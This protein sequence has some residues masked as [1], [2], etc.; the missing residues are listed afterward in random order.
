MAKPREIVTLQVGHFSNFIGAHWWNLQEGSFVYDEKTLTD[1][2]HDMLFREGR[3][4]NGEDTYVPR[5]VAIDLKGSLNT[6]KEDGILYGGGQKSSEVPWIGNVSVFKTEPSQKNEFLCDLEKEEVRSRNAQ[7]RKEIG[8]E[9]EK[10]VC[11][12]SPDNPSLAENVSRTKFYDLDSKVQLWS[13]FVG[14][15]YHPRS[16]YIIDQFSHNSELD[17]FE[18][19]G[20]GEQVWSNEKVADE[21]ENKIRFFTEECD[22]LQGFNLIVD[23]HNGFAGLGSGISSLLQDEYGSKTIVSIPTFP[24]PSNQINRVHMKMFQIAYTLQRLSSF[25]SIVIPVSLAKHIREPHETRKFPFLNYKPHLPYHT[26]SIIASALDTAT[27]P[28]R[29]KKSPMLLSEF[30]NSLV[31]RGMKVSGLS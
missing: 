1:I 13:D 3:T 16:I 18:H 22:N 30:E 20:L 6:L 27:L 31:Y 12:A 25:T 19:F 23:G 10:D 29:V 15:H 24:V 21:I 14:T 9:P 4:R 11:Q 17:S 7:I 8:S 5:L 26:S 2:N 28:Y